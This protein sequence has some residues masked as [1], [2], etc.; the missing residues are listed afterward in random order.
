MADLHR[1]LSG[2]SLTRAELI[3]AG[4]FVLIWFGM[5]VIMFVDFVIQK[6][7]P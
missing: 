4:I 2:Q 7:R 5:D 1:I 3:G 6:M